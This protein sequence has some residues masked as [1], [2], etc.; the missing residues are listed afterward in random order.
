MAYFDESFSK[1]FT[2]LKKHNDRDWFLQNK[3]VYEEKVKI[4]FEKLVG[5][6]IVRMQKLNPGFHLELKDAIFRLNRDI[7]F[8]K[9]KT[10]Y[11]TYVSAVVGPGGRKNM[12]DPG[13][14]LQLEAGS[15]MIFGGVYMPEKEPLSKIRSAIMDHPDEVARLKKDKKFVA[16]FGQLQGETNK[17]LPPEFREAAKKEPLI[18]HKQ[19]YFTAKYD[20]GK[21][22]YR[23]DLVDFIM[24]QYQA[25]LPW[26]EF[27]YQAIHA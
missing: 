16:V 7:R 26:T 4:P 6:L 5:D 12:A 24:K 25:G 11:K 9:D 14:Y 19:F 18:T 27:L 3:S 23:K 2:Q 20:D 8:S 17:V 22:L 1:F 15:L 21:T 10:P 13:M